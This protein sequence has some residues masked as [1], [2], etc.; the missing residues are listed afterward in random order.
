MLRHRHLLVLSGTAEIIF[1]WKWGTAISIFPTQERS[2]QWTILIMIISGRR[3]QEDSRGE[4]V[5]WQ[6]L[7]VKLNGLGGT[8]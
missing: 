2:Q 3:G 1:P 4:G 8:R 7:E 5:S 6:E